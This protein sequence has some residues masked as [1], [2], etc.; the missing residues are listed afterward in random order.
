MSNRTTYLITN[1]VILISL[2][3]I[4]VVLTLMVPKWLDERPPLQRD[5]DNIMDQVRVLSHD[6]VSFAAEG[7]AIRQK[8]SELPAE[9]QT[10]LIPYVN[11]EDLWVNRMAVYALGFNTTDESLKVLQERIPKVSSDLQVEVFEAIGNGKNPKGVEILRTYFN[12]KDPILARSAIIALAPL[13]AFAF[14][15]ASVKHLKRRNSWKDGEVFAQKAYRYGGREL[16]AREWTDYPLNTRLS[17][18][19]GLRP[20]L[21]TADK[22]EAEKRVFPFINACLLDRDP[23]L[24]WEALDW[25][26]LVDPVP[27][28]AALQGHSTHPVST[29]QERVTEVLKRVQ[30]QKS[31]SSTSSVDKNN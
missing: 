8:L 2:L 27:Y 28:E 22:A 7:L 3:A 1:G 12:S 13:D 4:G 25:M 16:I 11:S 21:T 29:L 18:L 6:P 14:G 20:F 19:H 26:E 31:K 17:F 23:Q 30:E 15:E 24:L 5:V 9:A 10:Y